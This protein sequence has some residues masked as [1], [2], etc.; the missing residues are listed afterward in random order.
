MTRSALERLDDDRAAGLFDGDTGAA[1]YRRQIKTLTARLES[2]QQ[3]LAALP[4]ASQGLIP[5]LDT[6]SFGDTGPLGPDSPGPHGTRPNGAS[7]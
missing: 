7:S 4:S 2:A 1:R 3:A 5:W 6:L